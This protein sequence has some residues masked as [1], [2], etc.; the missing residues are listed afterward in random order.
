[1]RKGTTIAAVVLLAMLGFAPVA[2]AVQSTGGF[3]ITGA[4]EWVAS[5]AGPVGA[6]VTLDLAGG[7]DF[8][9]SAD[10]GANLTSPGV[11]A[12]FTITDSSGNFTVL[13]GGTGLVKD[14]TFDS[15]KCGGTGCE[16]NLLP[17]VPPTLAGW[18]TVTVGAN[19]AIVDM[20]SITLVSKI[21][22]S[23]CAQVGQSNLVVQGTGLLHL[24][25]FDNTPGVFNLSVGTVSSTFSFNSQVG[26]TPTVPE[27]TTL[28]LLGT[29]L[30]AAGVIGRKRR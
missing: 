7:L 27:P 26:A 19:T 18:L 12:P 23:G 3:A 24:T 13:A 1:M 20:T 8:V 25:G 2:S 14:F 17:V 9:T 28:L 11:A 5:T 16:A 6:I 22:S 15:S 21:C 29:G 30:V 10:A 4:A